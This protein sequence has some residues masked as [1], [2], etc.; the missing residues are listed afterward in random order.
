[1]P[2]HFIIPDLS[3]GWPNQDLICE[4]ARALGMHDKVTVSRASCLGPPDPSLVQPLISQ[5]VELNI[6]YSD[7]IEL[8]DG[9]C[10]WRLLS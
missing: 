4:R 10:G 7:S 9:T 3:K 6:R 2:G 8:P 5:L 1:M